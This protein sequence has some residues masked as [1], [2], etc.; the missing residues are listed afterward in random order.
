[1]WR[2]IAF[3]GLYQI[4][5][6]SII[7]FDGHNIFG[8]HHYSDIDFEEWNH[9]NG[10]HLAIFFNIFVFLQVFNFLNARKLKKTELNVFANI[11]DNYL[12][13]LIVIGI[14]VSQLFIMQ[15]G[16]KTF[17]LVPLSASQHLACILIGATGLIWNL[18]IKL[19]LPEGLMNSFQLFREER[20]D[21][22][23]N[24]DSIFERWKEQ[25]AT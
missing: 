5:V 12:F 23:I 14:F 25:P 15:Y 1:M 19:L 10:Q 2:G 11:F 24:V 22:F 3:N 6:L 16:G 4:I 7:L 20:H 17:M 18:L 9:E 8:V 13:I 21:E